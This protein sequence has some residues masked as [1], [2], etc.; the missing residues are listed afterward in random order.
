MG[1]AQQIAKAL[2][3]SQQTVS[4]VIETLTKKRAEGLSGKPD[5]SDPP[6]AFEAETDEETDADAEAGEGEGDDLS[7]TV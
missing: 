3:V 5:R 7:G 4:N 1:T 2:D 6:L